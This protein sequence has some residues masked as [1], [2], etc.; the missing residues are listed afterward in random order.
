MLFKKK[1]TA[2]EAAEQTAEQIGQDII[3][4]KKKRFYKR[5]WF[6]NT[7]RIILLAALIAGLVAFIRFK[8]SRETGAET[9]TQTTSVVSRGTVDVRVTGSGTVQPIE[10]YT[11]TP[12]VTGAI[13]ECGYEKGQT[14]EKG[15]LLY[16][17]ED[18]EAQDKI[19][20]A[21]NALRA[22][23]RGLTG[24][25]DAIADA[26]EA[27]ETARRNAQRS[28]EDAERD[29][30]EARE[31]LAEVQERMGKLTVRAPIAG[32]VEGLTA[33]EGKQSGASLG[34]IQSYSDVSATVSFNS[35]Q[36]QNIKEGDRVTV[37]VASLMDSVGGRVARK[38][39]APHSGAD[40]TVMYNVKILLDNGL[41]LAA[42]TKISVTVHTSNGD[43]ECP[44]SGTVTYAEP[45]DI[46][47][48]EAG[49]ITAVYVENGDTVSAGQAI[50]RISS[51]TL[52]D[53]LAEREK[54]CRTLEEA[55][56]N[57]RESGNN[58]VKSAE[59]AWQDAK[60]GREDAI[61]N[62]DNAQSALDVA[63]K[64]AED[65]T[66]YSPVSG[67]VLE[68]YYKAGDNYSGEG[69]NRN[70]MVVADM[71]AMTFTI[72]VDE[73]DIS[74]IKEGQS[75][76]VTADALPGEMFS[77]TVTAVSRIGNSESGITGYPVSITVDEVGNLMSG[78]NVTAEINVGIAEDV[79]V[80]PASAI[81]MVGDMYYATLVT[82][83]EAEG[84]EVETQVQVDVGL[85]STDLF[86]IKSGLNEG[87]V[88]R[89]M[90][91]ASQDDMMYW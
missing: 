31:N 64:A 55:L 89:D 39:G 53:L 10:S 68:K 56:E 62:V 84:E 25:D 8:H 67:V 83:G 34:Q 81:F 82:P 15:D 59:K 38:Y 90:G 27:I 9:E 42:G 49:E 14:V 40:G 51:E 72:N 76:S 88:L 19:K 43:I 3:K 69:D 1:K 66:I 77:G 91:L 54:A 20:N 4:P 13:T 65:Y 46:E 33:Q 85:H 5:R 74:N 41:N 16:R 30:A 24:V 79:I 44:T 18:A 12:L 80:A 71:S 32:V 36:I 28:V 87:D 6:K 60:D 23:Q 26:A 47:V 61:E 52:E 11:L 2:P 86:E 29:L 7:I 63:K 22:A 50:A 21:E 78:M 75:V 57:A 58:S 45:E 70:L 17:F 48:E 35:L 73:L 37:G